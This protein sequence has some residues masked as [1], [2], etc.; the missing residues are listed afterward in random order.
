[1]ICTPQKRKATYATVSIFSGGIL[2]TII[3]FSTLFFD[4]PTNNVSYNDTSNDD[5]DTFIGLKNANSNFYAH[6]QFFNINK[7]LLL[8]PNFTISNNNSVIPSGDYFV[9][10]IRWHIKGNSTLE[11][12]YNNER[13]F[14][15]NFLKGLGTSQI[16]TFL[17]DLNLNE[18]YLK[19]THKNKLLIVLSK[20]C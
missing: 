16:K 15:L 1:M 19:Y 3:T 6:T 11:C 12:L 13:I 10:A 7:F 18:T 5:N 8:K 9:T 4:S 17:P 20:V 14:T 2:I